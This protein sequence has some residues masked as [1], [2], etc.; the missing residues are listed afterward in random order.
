M[1]ASLLG[2]TNQVADQSHFLSHKFS[3]DSETLII[4]RRIMNLNEFKNQGNFHPCH[5]EIINTSRPF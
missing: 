1:P 4:M 2:E 3:K 5:P